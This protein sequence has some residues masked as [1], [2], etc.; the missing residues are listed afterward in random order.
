MYVYCRHRT[1]R[2]L[3]DNI[4]A[5]SYFILCFI[6]IA[7]VFAHVAGDRP[8]FYVTNGTS[9]RVSVAFDKWIFFAVQYRRLFCHSILLLNYC[10]A[11]RHRRYH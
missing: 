8:I 2:V 1:I 3:F 10:A 9:A 5:V 6:C 7:D 4:D 11:I